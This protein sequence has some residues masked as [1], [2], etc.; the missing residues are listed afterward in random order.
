[1]VGERDGARL[2]AIANA[3]ELGA[4]LIYMTGS[5]WNPVSKYRI[6]NKLWP[7]LQSTEGTEAMNHYGGAMVNM[8]QIGI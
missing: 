4:I 2:S 1:M 5:L 8:E 7:Y 6:G 3:P